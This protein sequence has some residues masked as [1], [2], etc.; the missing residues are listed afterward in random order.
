MLQVCEVERQ[1]LL[2]VPLM[3]LRRAEL[4]T[5]V[6]TLTEL[7]SPSVHSSSCASFYF[8]SPPLPPLLLLH[9]FYSPKKCSILTFASDVS[10]RSRGVFDQQAWTGHSGGVLGFELCQ[11]VRGFLPPLVI[12]LSCSSAP[13]HCNFSSPSS[14]LPL[15]LSLFLSYSSFSLHSDPNEN[16]VSGCLPKLK[17]KV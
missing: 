15:F 5:A 3:V 7:W 14:F 16:K 1:P 2:R 11:T 12:L 10:G 17:R 6:I 4:E 8:S 13:S 9:Y